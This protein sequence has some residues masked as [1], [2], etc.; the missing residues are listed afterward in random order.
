MI[1][2]PLV[3]K[4][5][6]K[7]LLDPQLFNMI[8]LYENRQNEKSPETLIYKEFQGFCLS[9]GLARRS[10]QKW[11]MYK[12]KKPAVAQSFGGRSRAGWTNF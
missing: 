9:S 2:L 6:P 3:T 1:H 10:P 5:Y 8:R 11:V 12:I 7:N 4:S